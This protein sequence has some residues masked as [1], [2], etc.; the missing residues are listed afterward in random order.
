MAASYSREPIGSLLS[1]DA[2]HRV[3]YAAQWLT[4]D[5]ATQRLGADH[6]FAHGQRTLLAEQAFAQV[7]PRIF[8]LDNALL[9]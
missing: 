8:G 2:E 3:L 4:C 6:K 1:Q 9:G 5:E 7:D